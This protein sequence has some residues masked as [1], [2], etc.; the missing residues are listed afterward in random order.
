MPWG[1]G[2][3]LERKMK[4]LAMWNK[5]SLKL[6]WGLERWFQLTALVA[7]A[8]DLCSDPSIHKMIPNH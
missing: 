1:K 6:H 2:R 5:S 3:T 8:E 7:R 4:M